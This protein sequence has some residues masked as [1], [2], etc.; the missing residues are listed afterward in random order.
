MYKRQGDIVVAADDAAFVSAYTSAG[1]T[2]DGSATYFLAKH[3]G[4]MRA[5]ELVLTNRRLSAREAVDWGLI[6]K[7]VPRDQL[8]ATAKT[9]ALEFAN[10]P[11]KAYGGAKR[12]LLQAFSNTL[13][14]Q[15]EDET[16]SIANLTRGHDGREGIE[17]FAARR[18][19][20]FN[21]Q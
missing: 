21:G 5:K 15:L 19:P 1:I 20:Q 4:L 9:L 7:A 12:L 6:T 16:V 3:I 11:T 8:T 18:K 17:A 13:E 2:P 10:G 14:T